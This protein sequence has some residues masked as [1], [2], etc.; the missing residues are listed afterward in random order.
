MSQ[1]ACEIPSGHARDF[2]ED[3]DRKLAESKTTVSGQLKAR[4]GTQKF[5]NYILALREIVSDIRADRG[6]FLSESGSE[7]SYRGGKLNTCSG[8]HL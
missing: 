1:K 6:I 4:N 2:L 5:Q 7:R 3:Q 8:H